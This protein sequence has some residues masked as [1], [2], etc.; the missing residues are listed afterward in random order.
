MRI[1][2][3]LVLKTGIILFILVRNA[4]IGSQI[5]TRMTKCPEVEKVQKS[6][7]FTVFHCFAEKTTFPLLFSV[8]L[9][10]KTRCNPRDDHFFDDFDTLRDTPFG[11]VNIPYFPIFGCSEIPG[12]IW[13]GPPSGPITLKMLKMAKKH[14]NH[15]KSRKCSKK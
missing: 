2:P 5:R 15:G 1:M 7:Y 9:F 10:P 11:K 13:F 6:Q 12:S 8:F 3:V 4:D 14:Q